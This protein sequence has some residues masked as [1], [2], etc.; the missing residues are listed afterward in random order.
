M[1]VFSEIKR[2]QLPHFTQFFQKAILALRQVRG[3][4]NGRLLAGITKLESQL[5][6]QRK[7][8]NPSWNPVQ[9]LES[10]ERRAWKSILHWAGVLGLA[11]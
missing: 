10:Q 7:S 1:I 4:N 9:K 2:C 3:V 6:I 5:V 8:W 11:K